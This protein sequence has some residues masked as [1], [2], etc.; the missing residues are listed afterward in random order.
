[1]TAM[2]TMPLSLGAINSF[3]S[4]MPSFCLSRF[5]YPRSHSPPL[6]FLLSIVLYS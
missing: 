1:M 4:Q 6:P 5:A 3:T 2:Q